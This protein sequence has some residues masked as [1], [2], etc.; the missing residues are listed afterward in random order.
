MI[1]A[2]NCSG[3]KDFAPPLIRI[4]PSLLSSSQ[5]TAC[6]RGVP[7][8]APGGDG[9]MGGMGGPPPPIGRGDARGLAGPEGPDGCAF[10]CFT[11]S[12]IDRFL[13]KNARPSPA[14]HTARSLPVL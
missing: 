14:I 12:T 6:W 2:P 7:D 8:P 10:T 4:A 3:E 11:H 9:G 13:L 1:A 5:R